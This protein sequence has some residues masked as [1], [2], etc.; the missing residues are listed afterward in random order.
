MDKIVKHLPSKRVW[1]LLLMGLATAGTA[2][3]ETTSEPLA[4][5]LGISIDTVWMLLAATLVFFM[6]PG[7]AYC[8][9]GF[10][11]SKNTTNILFK[12]FRRLFS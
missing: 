12:N 6:Q 7:F 1:A 10:T 3:A 4:K 2:F 9:A 5:D 11:R 8:E